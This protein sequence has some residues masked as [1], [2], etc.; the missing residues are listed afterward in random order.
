MEEVPGSEFE[1]D[2][3]LVFIAAG[4]LGTENYVAKAFDVTLDARTNVQTE[5]DSYDT[6]QKN[7]FV[8]GDMHRGQSLVVWAI[9]E[10]RDVAA[11]V[12]THL[13]GYSNLPGAK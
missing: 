3:D 7:V 11:A 12:D 6:N 10:G 9:R 4:F 1:I 5:K 8:A 13:M 2:V